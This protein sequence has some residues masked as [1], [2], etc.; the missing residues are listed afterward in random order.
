MGVAE[1]WGRVRYW[2]ALWASVS[3]EFK[4]YSLSHIV[5][6]MLAAVK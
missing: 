2:A 4:D 3:N 6:D 5:W 1:L